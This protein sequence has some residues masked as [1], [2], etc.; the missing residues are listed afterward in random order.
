MEQHSDMKYIEALR[1]NNARLIDEIYRRFS[2]SVLRWVLANNGKAA[3][4][5]DLFQEALMVVY[6]RYCQKDFHLTCPLG[7]LL[8]AICR[9]KWYDRLLQKKRESDVR[10]AEAL[11]FEEEHESSALQEAEALLEADRRQSRLGRAFAQLSEQCQKLLTLVGEG[12]S[13]VTA[14]AE[15][16]GLPNANALYQAKHRCINR[17]KQ[18]YSQ[19]TNT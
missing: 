17:W 14:L 12:H 15:A 19:Q 9:R 2:Q 18:L 4:A 11:R 5:E 8:L 6:E 7:S 16:L 13:D 3:D 10:N 1:Q